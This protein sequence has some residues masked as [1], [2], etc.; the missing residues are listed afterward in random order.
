MNNLIN[1]NNIINN[2]NY[3]N[4]NNDDNFYLISSNNNNDNNNNININNNINNNNDNINNINKNNNH[5]INN[6]NF[7][8]N[9]ND[10]NNNNNINNNNTKNDY[11]NN[12][13]NYNN[14]NYLNNNNN[15]INNIDNNKSIF[16]NN[17]NNI[18]NIENYKYNFNNINN[19]FN[20]IDNNKSNFNNNNFNNID[21]NKSNFNNIKNT[22]KINN[23]NNK[24]NNNSIINN[25]N[26][27]SFVFNNNSNY[28]NNNKDKNNN[29]NNF[30]NNDN[31][32]IIYKD[33]NN[34]ILFSGEPIKNN[35]K[36]PISDKN[37]K[38]EIFTAFQLSQYP[39]VVWTIKNRNNEINIKNLKNQKQNFVKG[40]K[41][42][43]NSLQYFHNENIE[44]NNDYIISLSRKDEEMM[45]IW[46]LTNQIDLQVISILKISHLN[47]IIKHFCI[48][49]NKDFSKENSF[50]FIYGDNMMNNKNKR[51]YNRLKNK[52]IICYKFDNRLKKI[53]WE[54]YIDSNNSK[55]IKEYLEI[56]NFESI[57]YL[58][59][60]Y[61]TKQNNLY[62]INCN[63]MNI[64]LIIMKKN[65]LNDYQKIF[66]NCEN[67]IKHICA[68]IVERENNIQLFDSNIEGIFI[69]NINNEN[70]VNIVLKIPMNN[71]I[72]YDICLWNDNY[73]LASTNKGFQLRHIHQS[74]TINIDEYLKD[75]IYSKVRKVILPQESYSIIGIDYN[76][77]LCCW[78]IEIAKN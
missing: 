1:N 14:N 65:K 78:P 8:N 37:E 48:F 55:Y 31:E 4:N 63:D 62:L 33:N 49:N 38:C 7:D 22:N 29:N 9:K 36:I 50:L 64:N 25:N 69:W 40:H 67:K 11:R 76:N 73:I 18:N 61:S 20:H 56:N 21:N 35:E 39:I 12:N 32:D 43:I 59:T 28:E 52:E 5:N 77:E 42:Q 66:V 2:N 68:F 51:D 19:D 23:N 71:V 75:G 3:N 16:N 13:N 74:K 30:I 45:K 58:D 72:S 41:Y 54:N 34:T 26:N 6:I 10:Y 44:E 27:I 53:I 60:F 46:N 17:N 57:N 24:S 15:N 47:K 70:Y